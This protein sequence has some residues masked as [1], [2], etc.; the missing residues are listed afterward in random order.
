MK[1]I[2]TPAPDTYDVSSQNPNPDKNN[3][4]PVASGSAAAQSL[5]GQED[6]VIAT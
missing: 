5:K 4:H 3:D 6:K 2:Q 1:P